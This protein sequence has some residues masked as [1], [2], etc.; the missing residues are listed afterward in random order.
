MACLAESIFRVRAASFLK[1]CKTSSRFSVLSKIG[2]TRVPRRGHSPRFC[3]YWELGLS[4]LSQNRA[5]FGGRVGRF[6]DGAAYYDMGGAGGYRFGRRD[7]AG[8]IVDTTAGG[9]HSRSYD[10]EI[11]AT[12]LA[13]GAGFE[14]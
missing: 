8:L 6:R 4:N 13:Q 14:G 11:T 12:L 2:G 9:S 7:Y 1:N 3:V 10:G 5:R